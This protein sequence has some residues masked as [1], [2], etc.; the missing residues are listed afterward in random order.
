MDD[1]DELLR[2]DLSA[3]RIRTSAVPDRWLEQYV[4][5]KG[6]GARYLYE[7]LEAGTDPCSPENVL[8]FLLGP[9]TGYTPGEQRYAAVTKSPLT[10]AF[11]DS[12]GGGSFPGQLAGSLEGYLGVL[13]TGV[14]DEPVVLELEDS[15]A[16]LES[17]DDLWGL[18]AEATSK[19]FPDAAVACIGPAGEN[20]V[21][22]ATIASDGG[23]HHAGRGGAGTV[24]G[25]KNLKAVVAHDTPPAGLSDLR[26]RYGEAFAESDAGQWLAVSDTLETVDFANEVGVLPTRGWQEGSFEGVDGVG[27]ERAREAASGRERPDDPVPGGFRVDSDE[28][29]SVPR[30]ATPIVLGAGLGIDD[31]DAVATLGAVCDRLAMDVITAGNVVAWA[32]RASQ[33]GLIDRDLSFGDEAAVR[34]LIDEIADRSTPLGDVLADG[35]DRAAERFGGEELIPTVK[36]MELSSYDPRNAESMA[37]A[38]ATSDRGGCH[39]RA[40]PVE[41]E[42]VT[43]TDR[44]REA[45]V[46]A[47]IEEQNRRALLW[48]LIAD[49]FLKDVLETGH[50]AEWLSA[51][52]Y[53]HDPESLSRVGERVWTLVRLFNVREGFA[54]TDDELP[55]ALTDPLEDAAG[56]GDGAGIDPEM[57][58]ALLEQYYTS[59]GWDRRGRP[60]AEL[61]RR[62]ELT[63]VPDGSTP[64]TPTV[65]DDRETEVPEDD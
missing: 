2:V 38:Y 48:C 63:D 19:R 46:T 17:A 28:G 35:V 5:G 52:G 10:G 12:Y 33:D 50:A 42:P 34:R 16:T 15:E 25:S 56:S 51:V 1:R 36:G 23:D 26:E 49:D 11:L 47:V 40:R 57:F 24:M 27:I 64:V 20:G 61:L 41:Y 43:G 3:T 13:V 29:E 44:S 18:D 7:E 22:Y 45:R 30:G 37:L 32:I 9:L 53:D 31:F 55:P 39:R 65:D 62:L 54:R 4:G 21:Q 60:T 14:A 58:D 8:L 59:R 6:V